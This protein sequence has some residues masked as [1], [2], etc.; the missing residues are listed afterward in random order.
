MYHLRYRKQAREDLLTIRAYIAKR[1][2]NSTIARQFIAR[3]KA[4][5]ENLATLPG[6][7]GTARPELLP[8]IRSIPYGNYVIFFQYQEKYLDIIMIVEGH[9]DIDNMFEI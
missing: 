7:L 3:L 5:C 6:M 1:S 9:Q 8:N 2:G 4:E